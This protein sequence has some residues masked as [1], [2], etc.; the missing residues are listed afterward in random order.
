MI[1][2]FVSFSAYV[3]FFS[4]AIVV[5]A[6]MGIWG[7]WM[8]KGFVS[9]VLG[10]IMAVCG[11]FLWIFSLVDALR[12]ANLNGRLWWALGILFFSVIAAPLYYFL[13]IKPGSEK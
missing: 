13:I 6:N 9:E 4:I 11:V 8:Y 2:K 12:R 1:N 10:S 7:D 3:A 5:G